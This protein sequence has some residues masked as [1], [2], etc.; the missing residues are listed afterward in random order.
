M[1]SL[2]VHLTPANLLD[3][4]LSDRE[5]LLRALAAAG[6]ERAG[7]DPEQLHAA[8]VERERLCTT[9]L[10][11]S[12]A[13]PHVRLSGVKR[14]TVLLARN[15]QG[16]DFSAPDGEPVR[17]FL[18]IVGPAEEK[19]GYVKLMGRAARFLRAEAAGL[20]GSQDFLQAVASAAAEH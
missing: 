2:S 17:L 14:F 18:L 7:L 16:L 13:M 8:I 3:L 15:R 4:D 19:D 10:G 5:A 20:I 11:Q 12:V 1:A 9:A 6:A